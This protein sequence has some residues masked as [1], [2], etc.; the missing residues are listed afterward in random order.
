M[1]LAKNLSSN[2]SSTLQGCINSC[3]ILYLIP[4]LG[5]FYQLGRGEVEF[6]LSPSGLQ[7]ACKSLCVLGIVSILALTT[8]LTTANREKKK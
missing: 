8:K 5:S 2:L 6:S 4:V 3:I 7:I 1:S